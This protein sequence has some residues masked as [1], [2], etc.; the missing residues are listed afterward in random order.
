MFLIPCFLLLSL[1]DSR[2]KMCTVISMAIAS[3]AVQDWPEEWT[4]L[5]P[6]LL[7]LINNQENG[8]GGTYCVP[9]PL[10]FVFVVLNAVIFYYTDAFE[11]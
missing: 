5:L 9:V 1:D 8:N 3:I 11:I 4:D 6:Y 2:R 10:A 7:K